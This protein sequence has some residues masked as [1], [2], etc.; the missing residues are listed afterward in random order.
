MNRRWR[1]LRGGVGGPKLCEAINYTVAG[2]ELK[3]N[4]LSHLGEEKK[5]NDFAVRSQ[6]AKHD[7][8]I[9]LEKKFPTKKVHLR[10]E[11]FFLRVP[12]LGCFEIDGNRFRLAEL[13]GV[14]PLRRLFRQK[15]EVTT[16]NKKS[17]EIWDSLN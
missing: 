12:E 17:Q 2:S 10:P 16:E 4:R 8:D 1:L 15:F 14:E 6:T 3:P 9:I 13:G 7:D 5:K 11:L